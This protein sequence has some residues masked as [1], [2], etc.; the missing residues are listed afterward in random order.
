MTTTT[1]RTRV[2]LDGDLYD[3]A[4]FD[5]DFIYK[6]I[7]WAQEDEAFLASLSESERNWWGDWE[8]GHWGSVE[9]NEELVATTFYRNRHLDGYQTNLNAFA[10]AIRS[11]ECKTSYCQAGQ[12]VH[13]AGYRLMLDGDNSAVNCIEQRPTGRKTA[14]GAEEME[15]VPGVRPRS[16][17]ATARELMG[18]T[19]AEAGVYFEG[20][21]DV[22]RLKEIANWMCERRGI[23]LMWPGSVTFE[24]GEDV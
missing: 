17:E 19:Y 21:N 16:I 18:I 14:L 2:S 23:P 20:D 10:D 22:D 7:L 9:D 5:Y 1:E 4:E 8:Q 24:P 3:V 13:Q 12:R 6:A 11:G 15:D